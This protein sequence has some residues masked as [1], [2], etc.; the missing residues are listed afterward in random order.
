M[1]NIILSILLLVSFTNAFADRSYP[2]IFIKDKKDT[3]KKIIV[4]P[5]YDLISKFCGYDLIIKDTLGG[6]LK[7]CDD[8]EELVLPI[9]YSYMEPDEQFKYMKLRDTSH[10]ISTFDMKKNQ[11]FN[12]YYPYYLKQTGPLLLDYFFV[13][14][15]GVSIS[16]TFVYVERCID[17]KIFVKKKSSFGFLDSNLRYTEE[18][19]FLNTEIDYKKNYNNTHLIEKKLSKNKSTYGLADSVYKLIIPCQYDSLIIGPNFAVVKKENYWGAISTLDGTITTPLIYDKLELLKKRSYNSSGYEENYLVAKKNGKY[20]LITINNKIKQSF[21]YDSISTI[22]YDQLL[23]AIKDRMYGIIS[24]KKEIAPMIYDT[25]YR[26]TYSAPTGG[27]SNVVF[28][29]GSDETMY[30][31]GW[32]TIPTQ[33]YKAK[34]G[35]STFTLST[36]GKILKHSYFNNKITEKDGKYGMVWHG[37]CVLPTKYQAIL[38]LDRNMYDPNQ[39]WRSLFLYKVL[40]DDEK[41]G[42][43]TAKGKWI[44]PIKY[45]D[46]MCEGEEWYY[47]NNEYKSFVKYLKVE[48]NEKI[49]IFNSNGRCIIPIK[50]DGIDYEDNYS[51]EIYNRGFELEE[52]RKYSWFEVEKD[53]KIGIFNSKGR[54]IIPIEYN[55]VKFNDN[56][57]PHFIVTDKKGLKGAYS[58]KGKL[59][60]PVKYKDIRIDAEKNELV[61][62]E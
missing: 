11:V 27:V 55:H 54:C 47:F 52:D 21:I 41:Y 18:P 51:Y 8:M 16:D 40:S 13:D 59:L 9:I 60:L 24:P 3:T 44:L 31:D 49:G 17:G 53:E 50:Y 10:L 46:V 56:K 33:F 57:I 37:K 28:D 32:T 12:E 23:T 35:D 48:N 6:L 19:I 2:T 20:G 15:N 5:Q 43:C 1:R 4:E 61:G 36:N 22:S 30:W 29:C 42:V 25:I 45:D 14:S 62:E 58:P 26:Y 7:R 38:R 39:Q 34:L